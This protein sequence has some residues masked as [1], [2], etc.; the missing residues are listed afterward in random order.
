[1]TNENFLKE[2]KI[3]LDYIKDNLNIE[4]NKELNFLECIQVRMD[5]YLLNKIIS[6][7]IEEDYLNLIKYTSYLLSYLN[8]NKVESVY[9]QENIDDCYQISKR[10]N[11]DYANISDPYS[12]FKLVNSF[13][14]S[15]GN[16]IVVR[17]CDKVSRIK[18]LLRAEAQVKDESISDTLKD[19]INYANILLVYIKNKDDYE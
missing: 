5:T 16:G 7:F 2:L 13:G 6:L 8:I 4:D 17:M 1:M 3:N 19:L 10:K 18:N 15:T 12:N 11:S 14:I 9:I